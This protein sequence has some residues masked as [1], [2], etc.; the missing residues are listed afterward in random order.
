MLFNNVYFINNYIRTTCSQNDM[1]CDFNSITYSRNQF[2]GNHICNCMS[3]FCNIIYIRNLYS[4]CRSNNRNY[5][6]TIDKYHFLYYSMLC[7]F[8]L[9]DIWNNSNFGFNG[10]LDNLLFYII[11]IY[12][13]FVICNFNFIGYK[14]NIH[15]R[16]RLYISIFKHDRNYFK[17]IRKNTKGYFEYFRF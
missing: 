2:N 17:T 6:F 9:Y 12:I 13:L 4:N 5:T 8:N 16:S 14:C 3:V 1:L 7:Y 10:Y 11:D 15:Y